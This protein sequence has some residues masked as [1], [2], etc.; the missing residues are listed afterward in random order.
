MGSEASRVIWHEGDSNSDSGAINSELLIRMLASCDPFWY[1]HPVHSPSKTNHK[2]CATGSRSIHNR[3]FDNQT[4]PECNLNHM[5]PIVLELF[6]IC[7]I[8]SYSLKN[9]S[10]LTNVSGRWRGTKFYSEWLNSGDVELKDYNTGGIGIKLP[11]PASIM[12]LGCFRSNVW[13]GKNE[14]GDVFII[15]FLVDNIQLWNDAK[16]ELLTKLTSSFADCDQEPNQ[17][18]K[19]NT[20]FENQLLSI[21]YGKRPPAYPIYFRRIEDG[22]KFIQTADSPT[23]SLIVDE[24]GFAELIDYDDSLEGEQHY[25]I[26]NA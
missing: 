1:Y 10:D 24:E 22:K 2:A 15:G 12:F 18:I 20:P 17:F 14:D 9:D 6:R 16:I 26:L 7:E 11:N 5:A 19:N 25:K 8:V 21:A 4:D 13:I 23:H 3:W